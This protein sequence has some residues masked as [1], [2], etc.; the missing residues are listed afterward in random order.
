MNTN[1]R[2]TCTYVLDLLGTADLHVH[3]YYDFMSMLGSITIVI[4]IELQITANIL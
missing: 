3:K 1:V 4:V 2:S